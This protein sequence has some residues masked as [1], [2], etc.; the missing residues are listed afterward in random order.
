[1]YGKFISK[2]EGEEEGGRGGG[3]EEEEEEVK[4]SIQQRRRGERGNYLNTFYY[5]GGRWDRERETYT[6]AASGGEYMRTIMEER[7]EG[8]K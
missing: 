7:K 8:R 6:D 4:G 3:G 5:R 1:V 2:G